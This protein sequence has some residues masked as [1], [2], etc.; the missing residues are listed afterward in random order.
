MRLGINVI[1]KDG[2]TTCSVLTVDLAHK[3]YKGD[4]HDK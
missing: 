1:W 3:N 2:K 4:K